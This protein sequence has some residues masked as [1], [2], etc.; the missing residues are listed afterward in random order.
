MRVNG[1]GL[2]SVSGPVFVFSQPCTHFSFVFL[3]FFFFWK[4]KVVEFQ[5]VF[6]PWNLK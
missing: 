5:S 4:T 1:Q 2:L 6:Q 3:N